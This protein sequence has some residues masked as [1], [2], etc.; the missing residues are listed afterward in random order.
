MNE[1]LFITF[2]IVYLF[3]CILFVLHVEEIFDNLSIYKKISIGDLILSIIFF[4]IT[5]FGLLFV[6]FVFI[7]DLSIF[8]KIKDLFNKEIKIRK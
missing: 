8:D 5:L 3:L 1:G 2:L 7:Y 4:P 6:F